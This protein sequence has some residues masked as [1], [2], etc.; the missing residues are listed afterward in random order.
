MGR[1]QRSRPSK[2]GKKLKRIRLSLKLS[3]SQMVGALGVKKEAVYPASISLYEQG[4]REPPLAG[5]FRSPLVGFCCAPIVSL[6]LHLLELRRVA[7]MNPPAPTPLRV[8]T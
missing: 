5:A 6:P 1:S 7:K 2:L 3:Q 4:L 8:G